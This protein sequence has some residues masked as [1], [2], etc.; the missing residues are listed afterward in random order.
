M[1]VRN[2]LHKSLVTLLFGATIY[3]AVA[4]T[5][6]SYLG[7]SDNPERKKVTEGDIAKR[8]IAIKD[9]FDE[10]ENNKR[11]KEHTVNQE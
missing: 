8:I 10:I 2:F 3:Y 5:H 6:M 7:F 4:L 9:K 1:L 11:E